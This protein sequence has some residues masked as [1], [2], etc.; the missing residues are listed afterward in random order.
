MRRNRRLGRP[1]RIRFSF[2]PEGWYD[3][4][5]PAFAA[6]VGH[7]FGE[8]IT[9][10]A[11][12][13]KF[14]QALAAASSRVKLIEYGQS[15]EGRA[16]YYLVISSPDNQRTMK[17][18]RENLSRLADP[19][20]LED[21]DELERIVATNPAFVLIEAN[22]HGGEHSTM[23]TALAV[24][25]HLA[26]S[27][28]EEVAQLLN[29]LV[30]LIDP[31]QNPDGHERSVNWHYSAFGLQPNADPNAAEHSEPWPG[32][33]SNHYLFDLNRD[34]F[35]LTQRESAAKV[36]EY[37][38]WNPQVVLDLHEMGSNTTFFFAPPSL[39]VNAN[40]PPTVT[41]WW[42]TYGRAIA[43]A[44]DERGFAYFTREVFDSFF[45]GYGESWPT[46]H[47][48]TGITFEQ[49][50]VCG[51]QIRQE[52]GNVL[53]FRRAIEQ[54]FVATVAAIKAVAA[55][56][57]ERLRD[58][59]E[60]NRTAIDEGRTGDVQE[61]LIV[62]G[63]KKAEAHALVALLTAQGVEVLEAVEQFAHSARPYL[64]Q[65]EEQDFF[66]KGTIIIRMDQPKK[67]LL[68]TLFECEPVID[69]GFLAEE[70]E[71]DRERRADRIYDVTCW[72]LPLMQ[73]LD[74]RCA[75]RASSA[76][77][78]PYDTA[79]RANGV[80][81]SG[82]Y[83]T[84]LP[85]T[86]NAAARA[87]VELQRSGMKMRVA[88][89]EFTQGDYTFGRGTIL[90][91]HADN[92]ADLQGTIERLAREARATLIRTGTG[93]QERGISLGSMEMLP[94]KTPKIA[95][96][97]DRPT[98]TLSCGWMIYTLEQVYRM[99]FTAMRW[100]K[101][102]S[103]PTGRGADLSDYNVFVL[104][105]GD[106]DHYERC[107][108]E[109]E[110]KR[111]QEWVAAGG[112]LVAIGGAAA[113]L[114]RAEHNLTTC[115]A[116]KDLRKLDSDKR[117][118]RVDESAAKETNDSKEAKSAGS[119]VGKGDPPVP[120]EFKPKAV[121]G[122]VLRVKLDRHHFL[123]YGY[124]DE[125]YVPLATDLILTPSKL[126]WNVATFVEKDRL[127]VAGFLWEKM[128]AALPGNVYAVDEPTERGHVI[129]FADDPNFRATWTSLNRLFLNALLFAPSL[130]R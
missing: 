88:K 60:F 30:V 81:G 18:I 123:A 118:F 90:I 124:D 51:L 112:T 13:E 20:T 83:A 105:D 80:A 43:K 109:K 44:F 115:R 121:S 106:V 23:E 70:L 19:R 24:A 98:S 114:A 12:C 97:Y 41:R 117:A 86:S 64:A 93:W 122:A 87:L 5:V 69:P 129:L 48:A 77:T 22:V 82:D 16:L 47:G 56:R 7:E 116:I 74:A 91:S 100:E 58:F 8:R 21:D 78:I 76:A 27:R 52:D 110:I 125:L 85:W 66:P 59:Y 35:P 96:L 84:L 126:G 34:W 89:E 120:R 61:W 130:Q 46:F 32:G 111:L 94:L 36:K 4:K 45:P 37:L 55:S 68:Q 6:T 127:R 103:A 11:Q 9:T 39:P 26:A 107:L 2:N 40:I 95:M 108:G 50:S 99:P 57:P 42:E 63:E 54:H 3:T 128:A 53:T 67:R 17:D 1:P 28:D 113:H 71:R 15:Y 73:G 101:I 62:P 75:A 119:T 25:Y 29:D 14:A 49:A 10:H 38:R 33:R 72:A 92:G 104:P 65:E 31:L 79:A 102:A